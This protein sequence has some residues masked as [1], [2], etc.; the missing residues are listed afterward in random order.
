MKKTLSIL[1][2]AIVFV[3]YS[4]K[5]VNFNTSINKNEIGV[6]QINARNV[7]KSL[8][9]RNLE[10]NSRIL[11]NEINKSFYLHS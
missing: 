7:P 5:K 6:N 11:K 1:I 2:T 9:I 10:L 3:G 8:S 4:Q